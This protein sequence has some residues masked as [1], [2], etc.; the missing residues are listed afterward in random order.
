MLKCDLCHQLVGENFY[1]QFTPV[2]WANIRLCST[3]NHLL[4]VPFVPRANSKVTM[5]EEKYC[6]GIVNGNHHHHYG[7]SYGTGRHSYIKNGGCKLGYEIKRPSSVSS[8]GSGDSGKDLDGHQSTREDFDLLSSSGDSDYEYGPGIVDRL[9]HKFMALSNQSNGLDLVKRCASMEELAFKTTA[10]LIPKN[11]PVVSS[12]SRSSK[13]INGTKR[14]ILN[15]FANGHHYKVNSLTRKATNG[16]KPASSTP[17]VVQRSA[18]P[19]P[20]PVPSVPPPPPPTVDLYPHN[21]VKQFLKNHQTIHKEQPPELPVKKIGIVAPQTNGDISR[22]SVNNLLLLGA[23]MPYIK[24]SKSVDT[25]VLSTTV[26]NGKDSVADT[27]SDRKV[28]IREEETAEPSK[29]ESTEAA[30]SHA[31]HAPIAVS[32]MPKPDMVKT[33][34]RLFECNNASSAVGCDSVAKPS[35]VKMIKAIEENHSIACSQVLPKIPESSSTTTTARPL[36]VPPR[37]APE[38]PKLPPPVP[39]VRQHQGKKLS[40]TSVEIQITELIDV[41]HWCLIAH[42]IVINQVCLALD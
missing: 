2:P 18:L 3:A 36:P 10:L 25:L 1:N 19:A 21:I 11:V 32:E 12:A 42:H 24:R 27:G 7:R 17:K 30:S 14:K 6:N 40:Q 5:V 39:P 15:Q 35:H 33:V 9:R 29:D 22:N 8:G 31:R 34:K 23:P 26:A 20:P 16:I 37:V 13:L 4:C 41:E 28:E 38:P